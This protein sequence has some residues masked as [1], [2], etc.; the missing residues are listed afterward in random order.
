V[1]EG[2]SPRG[3]DPAVHR[4]VRPHDGLVQAGADWREAYVDA[5]RP[6]W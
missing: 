3:I 6:K 5:L 2:Q 1:E 4:S